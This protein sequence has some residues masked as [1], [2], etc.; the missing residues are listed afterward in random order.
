MSMEQNGL[1]E[2]RRETAK[3]GE[4]ISRLK[5]DNDWLKKEFIAVRTDVKD[6]KEKLLGRPSWWITA[7][8]TGLASICFSL[9]TYIFFK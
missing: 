6:I 5:A 8:I 2:L 1:K 9:L 4:D 3:Q 7:I